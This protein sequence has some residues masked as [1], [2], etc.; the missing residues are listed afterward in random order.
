M[1]GSKSANCLIVSDDS[2][3]WQIVIAEPEIDQWYFVC[4]KIFKG[5]GALQQ[6]NATVTLPIP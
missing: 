5:L 6:G 1:F 2:W 3:N 4:A